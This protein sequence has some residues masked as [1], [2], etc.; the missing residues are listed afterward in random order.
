MR[1]FEDGWTKADPRSGN[2]RMGCSTPESENKPH[3][4]QLRAGRISSPWQVYFITKC[5]DER[6]PILLNPVAAEIVIR[7]LAH[8]RQEG[9]I[10][11]LAFVVMPDHYHAIFAL[12]PG[13]D[14]SQLM[15]RI[16]SY[17]ANQIQKKLAVEHTVWQRDGFYDRACRDDSE[18]QNLAEYTEHSPIRRGLVEKSEDWFFSS[19]HADRR[20][21]LDWNWW[22]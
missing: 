9:N 21:L 15:R 10:K 12:A 16:G 19:A 4:R 5:V 17:T 1:R 22:A 14:L 13:V 8:V 20:A 18:V 2:C 6:R 3:A 11:L 7:C